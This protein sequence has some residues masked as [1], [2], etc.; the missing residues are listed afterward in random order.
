ML[1]RYGSPLKLLRSRR[2]K[3]THRASVVHRRWRGSF[4]AGNYFEKRPC[5]FYGLWHVRRV[6]P[7]NGH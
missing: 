3:P 5:N 1:I 2:A 7:F 4:V 6:R